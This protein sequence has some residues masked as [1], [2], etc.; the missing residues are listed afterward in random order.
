MPIV[1]SQIIGHDRQADG[2]ISIVEK[3]VDQL[4]RDRLIT[5]IDAAN[6][7]FAQRL[8]DN[9]A[10]MSENLVL[11]E[12][13]DNLRDIVLN[14][15]LATLTFDHVTVTQMAVV[16]RNAYR[17]A[18]GLRATMVGDFLST[19]TNAQLQNVFSMT[20]GQVTT[21]R[22]NRLTPQAARAAAIRAE[23]GQ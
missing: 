18:T 10:I 3:H 17:D 1:S 14:G 4:G 13:W 6:T 23:A 15:S 2:R 11:S 21:L 5:Y 20:A 16:V 7:D 22:N 19:L 9:A 12:G 8:A